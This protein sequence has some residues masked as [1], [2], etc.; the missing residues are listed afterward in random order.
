MSQKGILFK[1]VHHS[2]QDKNDNSFKI[3][4]CV[5]IPKCG[6]VLLLGFLFAW[7]CLKKKMGDVIS[8]LPLYPEILTVRFFTP[9]HFTPRKA[10]PLFSWRCTFLFFF[11]IFQP[12]FRF[13]LVLFVSVSFSF[14]LFFFF[15]NY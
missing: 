5:L 3:W 1:K 2:A 15:L 11:L 6:R 7:F 12:G 8:R 9:I 4:M 14:Q 10:I 13:F